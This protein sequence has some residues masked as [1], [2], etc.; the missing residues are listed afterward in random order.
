MQALRSYAQRCDEEDPLQKY[1]EK[2]HFPKG[3]NGSD[4][5]YF[6]GNSLGL[7]PKCTSD[8]IEAELDRWRNF[9]VD[10]HFQSD[11]PWLHYHDLLAPHLAP[12]VGARN[13]E[14][15]VMNSLTV[16]LHL[17]MVSFFQP[18]GSRTKIIIEKNA[19]LYQTTLI[20][21]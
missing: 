14:V 9:A 13:H 16:N 17:M 7:Q 15:V 6:C 2:F 1:R 4:C 12:L 21:P 3:K 10:G 8:Y 18:K 20:L 19:G 5:K 11:H